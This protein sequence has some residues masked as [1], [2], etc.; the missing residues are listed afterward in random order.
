MSVP[1][2]SGTLIYT[3]TNIQMIEPL[4]CLVLR[5]RGGR[6]CTCT[7]C[8]YSVWVIIMVAPLVD[9]E[10]HQP[11]KQSHQEQHLRNE[12]NKDVDEALEVAEKQ[13]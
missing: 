1:A 11:S 7:L 5:T 4:R 8:T 10:E 3:H 13:D 6:L 12:L 2:C 9:D